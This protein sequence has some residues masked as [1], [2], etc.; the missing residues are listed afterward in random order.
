MGGCSFA[1]PAGVPCWGLDSG[2]GE[3]PLVGWDSE[4]GIAAYAGAAV[5][6]HLAIRPN[7]CRQLRL[8]AKKASENLLGTVV[9]LGFRAIGEASSCPLT[10]NACEDKA[11]V[12]PMY[13]MLPK[14][15][16]IEKIPNFFDALITASLLTARQL[17]TSGQFADYI[18]CL[19]CRQNCVR[20]THCNEVTSKNWRSQFG[21]DTDISSLFPQV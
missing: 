6:G 10:D 13:G 20:L 12:K 2:R 7:R 21:A 5:A 18:W 4:S 16:P 19:V 3:C 11:E 8:P 1:Q 14:N 9:S 15:I 17:L